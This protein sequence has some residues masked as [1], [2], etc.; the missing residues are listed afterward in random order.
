MPTLI[1][2]AM[3]AAGFWS[4]PARRFRSARINATRSMDRNISTQTKASIKLKPGASYQPS[5]MKPDSGTKSV[6]MC[7]IRPSLS[8]PKNM[9]Y[10]PST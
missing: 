7:V 5:L 2:L 9:E 1:Q 6:N 8:S 4:P 3:R 10:G